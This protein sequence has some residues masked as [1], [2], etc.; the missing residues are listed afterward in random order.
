VECAGP[1]V[2]EFADEGFGRSFE[3]PVP[4]PHQGVRGRGILDMPDS[5]LWRM[6]AMSLA[7]IGVGPSD[8]LL[9]AVFR[10]ADMSD[11]DLGSIAEDDQRTTLRT[12]GAEIRTGLSRRPWR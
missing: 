1:N 8:C 12:S 4:G 2:D 9:R 3:F 11:S 6:D 7:G 5:R 10:T